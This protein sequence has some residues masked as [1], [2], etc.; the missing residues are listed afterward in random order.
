MLAACP[1]EVCWYREHAIAGK[2][3]WR[4]GWRRRLMMTMW[5]VQVEGTRILLKP[6]QFSTLVLIFVALS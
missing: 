3:S 5:K 2:L 6:R 4:S 1:R